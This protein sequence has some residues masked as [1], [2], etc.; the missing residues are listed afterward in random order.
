VPPVTRFVAELVLDSVA[1]AAFLSA[2]EFR[3]RLRVGLAPVVESA[4]RSEPAEKLADVKAEKLSG[5]LGRS[6]VV[7][8]GEPVSTLGEE[9]F[10]ARP[11]FTVSTITLFTSMV[12]ELLVVLEILGTVMLK[13]AKLVCKSESKLSPESVS[14]R[15]RSTLASL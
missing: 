15:F 7:G 5:M 1:P 10:V 9:R 2:I 11:A 4:N 12:T 13:G 14:F 8:E 6:L 3:L